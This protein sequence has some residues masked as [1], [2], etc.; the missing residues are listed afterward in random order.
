MSFYHDPPVFK[1]E[2]V[3]F[4]ATALF[5]AGVGVRVAAQQSAPGLAQRGYVDSKLCAACH[6]DVY[7]SYMRT[8]MARSFARPDTE[9]EIEDYASN[10]SFFHAASATWFEMIRRNG[11]YYQRR[12][13]IGFGS[14]QT[15]I[16]ETKIDYAIGS[17][18]HARAYL[19]RTANRKLMQLPMAWYSEDGG[20]WGMSPGYD[21]ADHQYGRRAVAYECFFCHNAY[22]EITNQRL[23]D[24]PVYPG[25]L[26][27]GIDCQRCH[28]PGANHIRA[29][30]EAQASPDSIRRAIV[31]PARL[32]PAASLEVCLQCHLQSTSRH[33]PDSIR[34]F[35]RAPFSY[36]PGQPLADFRIFF[37]HATESGQEGGGI[38]IDH[39]AYRLMQSQCF[40]KSGGGL[41]CV[42][43]HNPHEPLDSGPKA[44]AHYDGICRGCHASALETL[45]HAGRHPA[46]AECVGCHMPK[47]RTTDVV[48]VVMT[49]HL[50]QRRKPEGDLLAA[51]PEVQETGVNRYRG[52]VVPLYPRLLSTADSDLIVSIAQVQDGSNLSAGLPRLARALSAAYS[53]RTASTTIPEPWVE[54]GEA[55]RRSGQI[56]KSIAAYKE[57]V[58]RDPSYLAALI[59]LGSALQQAGQRPQ[60]ADAFRQA[61]K[62]VP[63]DARGWNALGTVELELGYASNALA[64]FARAAAIDPEMPE[65][66]NGLG[67]ALTRQSR[68]LEA[69]PEFREAIRIMPDYGI[70]HINLGQLLMSAGDF[71]QSEWEFQAAVRL[72]PGDP[73]ARFHHAIALSKLARFNESRSET[74]ASI[75]LN[76]GAAEAHD[77]LG[78]LME[79]DNQS[80]DARREYETAI[81][82][83]PGP[84]RAE[85]DLGMLLAKNGNRTDAA[86]HLSLAAASQE[87][88]I[89]NLA[90]QTMQE[91]NSGSR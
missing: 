37:D 19:H 51:M 68:P 44:A 60:A 89:R 24:E 64:A 17:G 13:Q 70:A 56:A 58:A 90:R 49:D 52:E 23:R 12:Y 1:R 72:L 21:S 59:G 36:T 3:V 88:A 82:L 8:A 38:E 30:G 54:Y 47:R 41:T 33:L 71:A 87:T 11:Q 91:L 29:A 16:D 80:D 50:I 35:G 77:L 74:E 81:R 69:E 7:N 22:P 10:K 62:A 65:S 86:R 66:H 26:P 83:H 85:L 75:R 27:E 55:L 63:G 40:L 9:N 48:H 76:P 78:N 79:K 28:G 6:A 31:N 2:G 15:N 20:H 45:M 4:L 61:T 39:S 46:G 43:C 67:I 5:A 53:N 34:R 25:N 18:S 57:G 14:V 73:S 84:S 42:T 32:S